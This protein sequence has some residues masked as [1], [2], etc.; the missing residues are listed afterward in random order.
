MGIGSRMGWGWRIPN[1]SFY[2]RMCSICCRAKFENENVQWILQTTLRNVRA[3]EGWKGMTGRGRN[4]NSELDNANNKYSTWNK[5]HTSS[6]FGVSYDAG[7][8]VGYFSK[9]MKKRKI[10]QESLRPLKKKKECEFVS[11]F[12]HRIFRRTTS[13]RDYSF[14]SSYIFSL[15]FHFWSFCSI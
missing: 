9:W 11:V 10:W 12:S 1:V 2:R 15:S 6:F 5:N 7:V 8:Y 13:F 14:L 3:R 4:R